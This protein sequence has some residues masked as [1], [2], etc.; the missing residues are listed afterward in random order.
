[1]TYGKRIRERRDILRLSMQEVADYVKVSKTAISKYENNQSEPSADKRKKIA[2]ILQTTEKYL[3]YG[4]E[5]VKQENSNN[6]ASLVK[7]ARLVPLISW[8]Q[9]GQWSEI[10]DIFNPGDA[11]EWIPARGNNGA[12]TFALRVCGD[13]MECNGP[14]SFKSGDIIIV[15]PSQPAESGNFVVAKILNGS[16]ENGEATFK[17]FIK[18]GGNTYL[19]PLNSAYPI[20]DITGKEVVI[21]GRVTGKYEDV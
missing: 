12:H 4:E 16:G 13:S 17:K 6:I 8:V 19:R 20:M 9:A 21:V 5:Q 18:D 11:E 3:M 14:I 1:M 10:V 7:L 15:D 2:E